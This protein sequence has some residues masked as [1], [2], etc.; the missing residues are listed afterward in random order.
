MAARSKT[1]FCGHSLA[2]F[3]CDFEFRLGHGCLFEC[4]VLS[5]KVLRDRSISGLEESY[6]VCV[7]V[8]KCLFT[9]QE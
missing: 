4:F 9:Y 7:S 1:R 2:G 3:D 8:I 5:G 6:H